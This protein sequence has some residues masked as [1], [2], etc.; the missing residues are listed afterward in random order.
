VKNQNISGTCTLYDANMQPVSKAVAEYS[1]SFALRAFLQ[2]GMYYISFTDNRTGL[3]SLT[4]NTYTTLTSLSIPATATISMGK[5]V[6]LTPA[7]SPENHGEILTWRT[8]GI[9][10]D[11]TQ[12]GVVTGLRPGTNSVVV[13]SESGL[14]ATCQV[15]VLPPA[16]ASITLP[17]TATLTKDYLYYLNLAVKPDGAQP[18][19]TWKSSAPGVASVDKTGLITAIKAGKATITAATADGKRTTACTVTVVVNE[20]KQSKPLVGGSAGIY[21]STKRLYYK[22]G[23]LNAEVYVYNKTGRTISKIDN[24]YFLLYDLRTSDYPVYEAFIGRWSKAIPYKGYGV[25]T[26]KLPKLSAFSRLDL[27]SGATQATIEADF[28]LRSASGAA[29]QKMRVIPMLAEYKP[30]PY[31]VV[32]HK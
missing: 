2:P 5:T 19:L 18:S 32:G 14:K 23:V 30:G 10:T 12:N 6:A 21:T 31:R 27:G 20:Y 1:G 28:Y 25:F 26:A 22:G 29:P 4:V 13:Q 8:L 15:T 3:Y 24:L 7:V 11:V 17:K 16:V 9:C